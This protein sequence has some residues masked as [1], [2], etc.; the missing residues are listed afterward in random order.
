MNWYAFYTKPR[1][2]AAVAAH[3]QSQGIA[4]FLPLYHDRQQGKE[5][6]PRPLFPCYLF[7][8]LDAASAGRSALGWTPGLRCVVSFAGVPAPVPEEAIALVRKRLA[9]VEA[10][11]GF[12]QLRFQPGERVRITGGPMTGLEAVFEGPLEPAARVRILIRFLGEVNRATVAVDSLEALP[13]ASLPPRRTRGHGRPIH[14]T[15]GR[16][17]YGP[18]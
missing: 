16:Q 2:E 5:P 8:A 9:E 13:S 17:R 12:L 14:P 7:A 6:R 3:L 1:Q 11:G 4:A 18:S 10:R 15:A